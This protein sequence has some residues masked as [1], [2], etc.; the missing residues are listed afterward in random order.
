MDAVLMQGVTDFGADASPAELA[1]KVPRSLPFQAAYQRLGLQSCNG[2]GTLFADVTA[3]RYRS[4]PPICFLCFSGGKAC[5]NI[6]LK[7][8][9]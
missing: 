9:D 6:L 5:G 8:T 7:I 2:A 3:A 4:G 1:C